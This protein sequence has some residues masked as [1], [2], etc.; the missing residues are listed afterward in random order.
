DTCSDFRV[1]R[2]AAAFKAVP[3]HRTPNYVTVFLNAVALSV[4]STTEIVTS[5]ATDCQ[6]SPKL[7]PRMMIPREIRMKCVAGRTYDTKR[8][9]SGSPGIGKTYPESR[10]DG[11]ITA[12]AI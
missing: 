5:A 11:S 6:M 8:S 10:T 9:G 12:I 4:I 1:R 7:A 2:L 3:R